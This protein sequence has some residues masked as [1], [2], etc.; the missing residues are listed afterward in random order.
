MP[1]RFLPELKNP[2]TVAGYNFYIQIGESTNVQGRVTNP[3][4]GMP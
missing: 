1:Q 2:L 4:T 3:A